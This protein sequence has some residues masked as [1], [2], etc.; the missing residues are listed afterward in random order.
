MGR[1]RS[2]FCSRIAVQRG[3]IPAPRNYPAWLHPN[4][5]VQ[6]QALEVRSWVEVW[7]SRGEAEWP[8]GQQMLA[9]SRSIPVVLPVPDFSM[10]YNVG[11]LVLVVVLTYVVGGFAQLC[12]AMRNSRTAQTVPVDRRKRA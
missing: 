9:T 3:D 1:Y 5:L 4:V 10:P 12:T 2:F 6:L 7:A 8:A 11:C